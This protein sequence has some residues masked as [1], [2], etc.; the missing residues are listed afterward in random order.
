MSK[1]V[2]T[3]NGAPGRWESPTTVTLAHERG[4]VRESIAH[5]LSDAGFDVLGQ[6]GT[7]N[8]LRYLARQQSP[9]LMLLDMELVNHRPDEIGRLASEFSRS[10]IVILISSHDAG[11]T[12]RAMQGGAKGCLSL[13]LSS[14]EFIRGLRV[15]ARGDVFVSREVA[16]HMRSRG[17]SGA[18]VQRENLHSLSNRE[19]EVLT[20]ITQGA[21]NREIAD[22]LFITENSVKIH[23]RNILYKLKLRNR[24]QAAVYGALGGVLN[25]SVE[26]EVE[27][28]PAAAPDGGLVKPVPGHPGRRP[29]DD[30]DRAYGRDNP[31][32]FFT[33]S[34]AS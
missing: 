7:L 6:V 26:V 23:V 17:V 27:D 4:L 30:I 20:L 21:T 13:N 5:M 9:N 16:Q 8:D 34:K 19:L 24:Q 31:D 14:E 33:S 25:G 10:A 15:I 32:G 18:A 11:T 29:Y 22:K 28:R 3:S 2:L 1:T 12:M